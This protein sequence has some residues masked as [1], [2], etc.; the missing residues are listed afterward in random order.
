MTLGGYALMHCIDAVKLP[1]A[2]RIIDM[3]RPTIEK[4][5]VP[6]ATRVMWSVHEAYYAHWV[7]AD[8]PRCLAIVEAGLALAQ[9]SGMRQLDVVLAAQGALG[10]LSG[11]DYEAA[12]RYERAMAPHVDGAPGLVSLYYNIAAGWLALAL[13][14]LPRAEYHAQ[15]AVAVAVGMGLPFG[16][17]IFRLGVAQIQFERGDRASANAYL[18]QA[19]EIAARTHSH[20]L[21]F[22]ALIAEAHFALAG[23]RKPEAS[24]ALSAAFPIAE[25]HGIVTIPWWRPSVM[26]PL[27]GLAL[28]AGICVD[29]VCRLIRQR[30]LACDAP[31]QHLELWPRSLRVRTLGRFE[32]IK[33]DV[34]IRFSGKAQRKPLDMLKALIALGGR[35][36]REERLSELLWA[37]SE[38]DAAHSAFTT[39]LSRLRKLVGAD[40]IRVGEGR[41]SLDPQSVWVDAW[42]LEHALS[43]RADMPLDPENESMQRALSLYRGPFLDGEE[44]AAWVLPLRERLRSKFLRGLS[45]EAQRQARVGTHESAIA[46]YQK[47]LETDGLAEVF[48]RGLMA[49]YMAL[50]RRAEAVAVF[51]R[52]RKVLASA[53]GVE[54]SVETLNLYQAARSGR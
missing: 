50:G 29:Y 54:P 16:E 1:Q 39:T 47:G 44:E 5:G 31:V 15:L 25:R 38:G 40:V 23:G 3:L 6:I 8:T 37:D 12:Q 30:Q 7:L 41:V 26:T 49:S 46:L 19:K 33:D 45:A 53:L 34:P 17:A 28:E 52:C 2:S 42:A 36:V 18:A 43:D 14:D 9:Q 22:F 35:D 27:C 20:P 21:E 24:A 11:G 13:N 4:S 48:Y 51:E 10:A 32:L